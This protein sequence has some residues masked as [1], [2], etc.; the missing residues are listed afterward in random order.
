MW[1]IQSAHVRQYKNAWLTCLGFALSFVKHQLCDCLQAPAQA[2]LHTTP[3]RTLGLSIECT[4]PLACSKLRATRPTISSHR[5][6]LAV[7]RWQ[8]E[9]TP[10]TNLLRQYCR[11]LVA[12]HV[13]R[14]FRTILRQSTF[15]SWHVWLSM[16]NP[17]AGAC[18]ACRFALPF[19]LACQSL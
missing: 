13:S 3:H 18:V 6:T 15:D 10:G 11:K 12:K 9:L 17:F 14:H 4:G 16:Y 2:W 19:T 7:S 8:D 1:V 5:L